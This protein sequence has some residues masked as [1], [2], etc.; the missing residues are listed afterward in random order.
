M[1]R[2]YRPGRTAKSIVN[3]VGD[4]DVTQVGPKARAEVLD[5]F[6][7]AAL[8]DVKAAS[9]DA[10]RRPKTKLAGVN[11]ALRRRTER[12]EERNTLRADRLEQGRLWRATGI[13]EKTPHID[14]P[15][16]GRVLVYLFLAGLD[17]YVFAE[18]WAVGAD[19]RTGEVDWWVGGLFG[20]VVFGAGF[21]AAVQIKREMVAVRQRELLREMRSPDPAL[22]VLAQSRWLTVSA[23][24]FFLIT[25][26]LGFAV[27]V[28]S[29]TNGYTLPMVM[30]AAL[31]PMLAA[32]A[33]IFL[34]DPMERQEAKPNLIDGVLSRRQARIERKLEVIEERR[35]SA[36]DQVRA[37]YEADRRILDVEQH[38]IGIR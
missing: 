10:A 34:H 2:G 32:L 38:D 33:E 31:V 25:I 29:E 12:R 13:Y 9:E 8:I 23:I 17:F 21:L 14:L 28:A 3:G 19:S 26:A 11:R 1:A 30:L 24:T 7:S 20:L 18:A 15:F 5:S 35:A 36:I 27:R 37:M 4:V 16:I 6:E 22:V